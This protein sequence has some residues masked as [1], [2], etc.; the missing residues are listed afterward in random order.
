MWR[1]S[2]WANTTM[3][4]RRSNTAW[5]K[6]PTSRQHWIW[7]IPCLQR[8]FRSSPATRKGLQ[9]LSASVLTAYCLEDADRM[10][11]GFQKLLDVPLDDDEENKPSVWVSSVNYDFVFTHFQQT[12]LW[13]LTS[14]A[15]FNS[16]TATLTKYGGWSCAVIGV[17]STF[18]D[19]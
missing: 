6:G 1:S 3:R 4:C 11:D 14:F 16:R 15:S 12:I 19:S 13:I 7:V 17:I 9:K 10:R 8:N 5:K 2:R 18:I